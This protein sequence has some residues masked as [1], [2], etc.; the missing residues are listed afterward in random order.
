MATRRHSVAS[1]ALD[2]QPIKSIRGLSGLYQD[3]FSLELA[4]IR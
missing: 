1:A 3:L 2:F 4:T